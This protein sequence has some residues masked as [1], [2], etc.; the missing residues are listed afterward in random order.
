MYIS[1]FVSTPMYICTCIHAYLF[2]P[3][4]ASSLTCFNILRF[5]SLRFAFDLL[6]ALRVLRRAWGDLECASA[7]RVQMWRQN[8]TPRWLDRAFL[9]L[10]RQSLW[11]HIVK[12]RNCSAGVFLNGHRSRGTLVR[13]LPD[14]QQA[15]A[16]FS[17]IMPHQLQSISCPGL[18][19]LHQSFA[20]NCRRQLR[21]NDKSN[22]MHLLKH[23]TGVNEARWKVGRDNRRGLCG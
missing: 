19:C 5:P 14:A 21:Y 20:S 13:F 18:H 15:A 17:Q 4:F 10:S 16:I 2:Q 1:I 3:V 7:F 12:K 9:R 8:W 23:L 22:L 6:Q 11:I